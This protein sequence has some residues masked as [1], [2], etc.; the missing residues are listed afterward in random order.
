MPVL[1]LKLRYI[2]GDSHWLDILINNGIAR[3]LKPVLVIAPRALV[4]R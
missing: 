1:H 3:T 4:H 2:L